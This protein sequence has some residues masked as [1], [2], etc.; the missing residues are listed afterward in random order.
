MNLKQFLKT[1]IMLIMKYILSS[2]SDCFSAAGDTAAAF[3]QFCYR[4]GYS[5]NFVTPRRLEWLKDK[6]L[7]FLPGV[8]ASDQCLPFG[9]A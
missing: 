8:V 7:V 3:V 1:Y 9:S 6:R 5:V 4:H 2:H